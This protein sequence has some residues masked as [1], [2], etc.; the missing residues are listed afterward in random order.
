MQFITT[1]HMLTTEIEYGTGLWSTENTRL[2]LYIIFP[3]P[4][5]VLVS[6]KVSDDMTWINIA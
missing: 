2:Y 1:I 6:G 4:V 5:N 3:T